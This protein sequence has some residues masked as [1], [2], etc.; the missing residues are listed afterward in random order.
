VPPAAALDPAIEVDLALAPWLAKPCES[1]RK[2]S[3]YRPDPDAQRQGSSVALAREGDQLVAYG[4]NPD[5]G[6]IHLVDVGSRE[7][8]ASAEVL[9]T[10]EQLQVLNDGRL[11]VSIGDRSHIEVFELSDSETKTLER[12]CARTVSALPFGLATSKDGLTLAVTTSAPATLTLFD[13]ET[14]ATPVAVP[15]PRAPRGVLIDDSGRA[16]VT[17]L[18]GGRMSTVEI[19]FPQRGATS[20]DMRLRTATQIGTLPDMENQRDGTQAYA[21]TSVEITSHASGEQRPLAGGPAPTTLLATKEKLQRQRHL[22]V[23]MVSVDPGSP[24]RETR[25]YY[26]PPPLAGVPKQAPTAVL[27]DADARR[28][29]STRVLA[30]TAEERDGE[31]FLPRAIAF[32]AKSQSLFVACVGLDRVQELDAA[33]ADPMRSPKRSYDVPKGPTG[34]AI[35]DPEGLMLVSS[36]FDGKLAI[37]SLK[38]GITDAV[39][40]DLGTPRIASNIRAGREMFFRTGDANITREGLACASCHPD[41]N[42]DGVTWST[43]E[44]P[45]QTPMLAGRLLDTAPYGWSRGERTLDSY[46]DD[47]MSRLGGNGLTPGDRE[48]LVIYLRSMK[49]PP[50]APTS[51]LAAAGA[52][53]FMSARCDSCHTGVTGTDRKPHADDV[54]TVPIDTPSLRSVA[55][56]APYF[57][58]ARYRSLED[59][60][61]DPKSEMP[62]IARLKAEDQAALA[63]FLRG[64]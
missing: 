60:L 23:P 15:L 39:D 61:A 63:A 24:T 56:T 7:V 55:M 34:I 57:H 30:P 11:V 52:S 43:P 29:M 20:I 6:T 59:L 32:R 35:A 64:L 16:F 42:D 33:S 49:G 10:P 38:S 53:V 46:V 40:L 44:G 26:G 22:V 62:G 13:V 2:K 54:G 14:F 8:V 27:V 19:A 31:C 41:G 9:G 37:V 28:T 12:R 4:T 36:V 47:T 5:R 21:L 48:A 17:H 3:R 58:D 1:Q 51:R 45:R 18:V 25:N 50:A